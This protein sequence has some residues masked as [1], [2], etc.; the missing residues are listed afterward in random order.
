MCKYKDV[1]KIWSGWC[2]LDD[3]EL[4]LEFEEHMVRKAVKDS[5]NSYLL[6]I[7]VKKT[8]AKF[9]AKESKN[10]WFIVIFALMGIGI[11][12]PYS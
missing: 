6:N 8:Y 10:F 3:Q 1:Y 4:M 12:A 9:L 5:H 11:W 7:K 2:V